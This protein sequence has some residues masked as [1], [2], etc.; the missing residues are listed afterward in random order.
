M[1]PVF[2]GIILIFFILSAN[3]ISYYR[4]EVKELDTY[5]IL[6]TFLSLILCATR[7][8]YQIC[9]EAIKKNEGLKSY[10]A[11]LIT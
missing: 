1:T 11:S 3:E 7:V 5:L 4:Q 10:S 9:L 6:I 2:I 8:I